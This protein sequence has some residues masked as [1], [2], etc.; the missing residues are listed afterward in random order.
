MA[1]NLVL[2]NRGKKKAVTMQDLSLKLQCGKS[3][4]IALII[5][6]TKRKLLEKLKLKL[7]A[8]LLIS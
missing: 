1:I 8:K 4:V 5:C 6:A 2:E 7:N 3:N